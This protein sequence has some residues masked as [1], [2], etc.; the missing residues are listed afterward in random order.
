MNEQE[1]TK[2]SE[3]TQDA[4][5]PKLEFSEKP[6]SPTSDLS[7]EQI[8]AFSSMLK[9]II[10]EVVERTVQSTK[11]KRFSKLEEGKSVL[12]EVLATLKAQNVPI[13][14][15]VEREYELRDYVDKRIEAMGGAPQP[16]DNGMSEDA[17]GVSGQ[18]D[19]LEILKQYGLDTANPDVTALF[20][21]KN[22]RNVDHFEK[23]V[24]KLALKQAAKPTPSAGSVPP[25][26]G[27]SSTQSDQGELVT[28]L[29]KAQ[30]DPIGNKALIAELEK[31]LGW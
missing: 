8:E 23:E 27:G 20:K 16:K 3:D 17:A 18:F 9:P 15:E 1:E 24:A 30:K 22:Y 21:V 7:P 12:K 29:A 2:V 28:Q 5:L 4:N 13:P 31:K 11:D 26:S 10:E 25:M 19:A 6:V 14:K